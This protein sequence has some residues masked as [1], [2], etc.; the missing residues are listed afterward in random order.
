MTVQYQGRRLLTI[1]EAGERLGVSRARVYELFKRDELPSVYVGRLR[2]VLES[3]LDAF[4]EG[5]PPAAS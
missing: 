4:I 5:L 3:D 2:R 1:E